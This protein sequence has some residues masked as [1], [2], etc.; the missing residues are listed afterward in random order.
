MWA[1]CKLQT[2]RVSSLL[3]T[4][5]LTHEW[6]LAVNNT[7][8]TETRLRS[9]HKCVST[10]PRRRHLPKTDEQLPSPV[11]VDLIFPLLGRGCGG[12]WLPSTQ[13]S[14]H[15]LEVVRMEFRANQDTAVPWP[16][17][18]FFEMNRC[19]L[20]K[21]LAG[22][23]PLVAARDAACST[24]IGGINMYA[25]QMPITLNPPQTTK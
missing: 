18:I 9:K 5:Y 25:Y 1:H 13:R 8:D 12:S 17:G 6:H 3:E 24:L 7:N 15:F 20:L 11:P 19:H 10:S 2:S 14:F 4:T 16:P 23:S 21:W 22:V